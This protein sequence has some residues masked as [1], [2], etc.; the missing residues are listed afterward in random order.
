MEEAQVHQAFGFLGEEM[1]QRLGLDFSKCIK[2][3]HQIGRTVYVDICEGKRTDVEWGT[4]DWLG[5]CALIFIGA[6]VSILFVAMA[7]VFWKGP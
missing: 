2:E 5:F 1:T 7:R 6:V 4:G 3:Q